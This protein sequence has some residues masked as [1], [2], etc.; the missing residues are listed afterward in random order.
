MPR[1]VMESLSLE[2]IRR[3]LDVAPVLIVGLGWWL[4][5]MMLRL[6]S[7]SDESGILQDARQPE[8]FLCSQE[9][10]LSLGSPVTVMG[11]LHPREMT[12]R[13][14]DTCPS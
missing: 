3:C 4:D 7:N 8:P 14:G 1:E 2:V 10:L 11:L 12:T 6:S 5:W 9:S 13:F